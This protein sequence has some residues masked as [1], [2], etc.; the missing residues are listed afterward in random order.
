MRIA[1]RQKNI[2]VTP[3]LRVYIEAKLIR[4]VEKLL[5]GVTKELSLMDLE[6]ERTTA[7][8]RKGKVYRAEANISL[9]KSLLRAE[10]EDEDIRAA[11]DLL[12]EELKREITHFKSKRS[13]QEFRRAREAKKRLHLAPAARIRSGGRVLNEGI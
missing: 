11:C 10:A 1:I 8:H 9:G 5:Q 4:P 13:A 7:H 3:A 2:E 12:E 6:L